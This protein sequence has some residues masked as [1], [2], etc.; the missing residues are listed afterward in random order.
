MSDEPFYAPNRQPAPQR[1]PRPGE[2]LW[3][4]RKSHHNYTCELR[5]HSE[6]GVEAQIFR[7]TDLLV[8][9]RFVLRELAVGWAAGERQVLESGDGD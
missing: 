5:Y 1:K 2:P 7:D 4:L 8:S 6:W 3:T 9:R